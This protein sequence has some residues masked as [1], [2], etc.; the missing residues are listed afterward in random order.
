M[1]AALDAALS[2]ILAI[3]STT[4]GADMKRSP[5][6]RGDTNPYLELV[7]SKGA[8]VEIVPDTGHFTQIEAAV[9]VNELIRGF[10]AA[11]R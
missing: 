7:K 1:E 4:R 11:N 2:P 9:Q 8:R 6:K 5:L 10:L 3:Q